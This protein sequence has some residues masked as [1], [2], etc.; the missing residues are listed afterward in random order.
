[1]NSFKQIKDDELIVELKSRLD[2]A[3]STIK[4]MTELT[5]ELKTVNKKLG[6]SE[7]LKTHFIS[8]ITNEIINPFTSIL[9]LSRN[10]IVVEKE[11]WKKV[12][13]MVSL[14]HSEAF[15]LDFQ[16]KNIF[17]AAKL[18][19]GDVMPEITKSEPV[20]IIQ[21]VIEDF[22][23]DLRK[24]NI[25]VIFSNNIKTEE[26]QKFHFKTDA[27]KF[28]LIISNLI[29]N[30]IKFSFDDD[31]IKVELG[32][33]NN[34]LT[35]SIQDYGTGISEGNQRVIFDRFK[36]I[37]SGINSKN[38]GHGLGLSITKALI[39]ILEGKI[40]VKSILGKGSTFGISI[41]ESK[42]EDIDSVSSNGNDF[43]FD[44][45]ESF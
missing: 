11:N 15:N 7:S 43:L 25:E 22:H 31:K 28:K 6:E 30:A 37:D 19:A 3:R 34:N 8:H 20:K 13:S 45:E 26:N 41:P 27:E 24:K 1:M 9:A 23:I 44:E 39:D 14:I 21:S 40:A 35:I 38:R 32:F 33:L 2:E 29:S 4:E 16:L 36:R 10:I 42:L 18:E 12:I 5:E 17:M